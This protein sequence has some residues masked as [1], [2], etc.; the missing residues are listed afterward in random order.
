MRFIS[1][2][3]GDISSRKSQAGSGRARKIFKLV[4]E[5]GMKETGNSGQLFRLSYFPEIKDESVVRRW[6]II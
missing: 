1:V 2:W 6:S 3:N 4:K 5:I